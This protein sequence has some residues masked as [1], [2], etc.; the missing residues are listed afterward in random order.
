MKV[1]LTLGRWPEFED[2]RIDTRKASLAGDQCLPVKDGYLIDTLDLTDEY[3]RVMEFPV[4]SEKNFTREH[5]LFYEEKD[6]CT[7]FTPYVELSQVNGA[8]RTFVLTMHASASSTA[9]LKSYENGE[10]DYKT[11]RADFLALVAKSH[12]RPVER[13]CAGGV[14][15]TP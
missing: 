6:R 3:V 9:V 15:T 1:Y 12:H 11:L 10:P 5:F 2:L 14:S 7:G 4:L 8:G 13:A